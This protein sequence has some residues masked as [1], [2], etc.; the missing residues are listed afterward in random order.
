M[1]K[2]LARELIGAGVHFGHGASR[3]NPK[4]APYIFGKRGMIHIIDV[5]ET[6]RGML[7]AKK[8][9]SDVVASGKDVVFV[10]TKRQAQKGVEG[11]AASS[12]MHYVSE[13]WLG[14]MLTNFRTVRSRLQ[15]LEELE[16]MA[17]KSGSELKIISI[18]TREGVQLKDI[19]GFAAILRYDTSN[20]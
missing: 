15:R 7:I 8:L 4:M 17:D 3:W 11:I 14:G 2:E 13:R 5:R 1:R 16:K 19:G 20:S 10:G 9:L 12:G 18:D 6:L